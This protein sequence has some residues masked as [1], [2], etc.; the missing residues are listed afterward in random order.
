MRTGR[1]WFLSN[2]VLTLGG[3]RAFFQG[4][5]QQ[6]PFPTTPRI[7]GINNPDN[8]PN[9]EPPM[10]RPDPKVQ[11]KENQ[12]KLRGDADR[13]VQLANELKKQADQTDQTQVLSVT[14]IHKAEEIEKLA[15]KIKSLAR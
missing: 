10:P 6:G 3:A 15:K 14:L 7:P 8:M 11:L 12:K 5:W 4:S 13:L 1:R 9:E 2:I